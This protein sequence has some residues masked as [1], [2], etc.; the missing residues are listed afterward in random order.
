MTSVEMPEKLVVFV[1]VL[2]RDEPMR[3]W[4]AG[5]EQLP[6]SLRRREISQ[7]A[8]RMEAGGEDPELV[9]VARMLTQPEV[10]DAVAG[11]LRQRS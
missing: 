6:S 8:R 5:L 7:L 10:F 2:E 4:F 3:L 11:I 1:E 9:A